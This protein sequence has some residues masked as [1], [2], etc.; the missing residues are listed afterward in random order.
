MKFG[1]DIYDPLRMNYN[2]F[3]NTLEFKQALP[4]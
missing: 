1:T 4:G 3:G 2:D